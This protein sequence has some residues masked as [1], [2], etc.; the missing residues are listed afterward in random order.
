MT[1]DK[2]ASTTCRWPF[3]VGTS[4]TSS[5]VLADVPVTVDMIDVLTWP[6]FMRVTAVF[7]QECVPT[8]DRSTSSKVWV[9][10]ARWCSTLC[11]QRMSHVFLICFR[12]ER[13]DI[14]LSITGLFCP[15]PVRAQK[16]YLSSFLNTAPCKSWASKGHCALS[17]WSGFW[18][19]H[20]QRSLAK[21]SGSGTHRGWVLPF[22]CGMF[23]SGKPLPW[24][25]MFLNQF[26]LACLAASARS[27]KQSCTS[28]SAPAHGAWHSCT[29]VAKNS[30]T[31]SV[32]SASLPPRLFTTFS[33]RVPNVVGCKISPIVLGASRTYSRIH[34]LQHGWEQ[35]VYS[36][37][38][39]FCC[40]TLHWRKICQLIVPFASLDPF[41]DRFC[42]Y[43]SVALPWL[44]LNIELGFQRYPM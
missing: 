27:P 25:S 16:R 40:D 9:F 17:D 7:F 38:Q 39:L 29:T 1:G 20:D 2:M 18:V 33:C 13:S 42:F 30:E 34:P 21:L 8:F 28:R 15:D 31:C 22:T 35:M 23:A 12:K 26:V 37:N 19:I 11:L 44:E 41:V 6:S 24:G 14:G 5:K 32:L 43:V 4:Y 10:S 3:C 36:C